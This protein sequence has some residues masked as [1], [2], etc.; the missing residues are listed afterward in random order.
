MANVRVVVYSSVLFN[1]GGDIR[2]WADRVEQQFTA[3]AKAIAPVNKRANKGGSPFPVGALK[4]SITGNVAR[5]GPHA[6]NTEI[7]VNVPYATYVLFGTSSPITSP[8]G[9][10]MAVPD[11]PQG[12]GHKWSVSG[13]RAQPFLM[14]AAFMTART[15]SSLRGFTPFRGF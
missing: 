8:F 3:N 5:V 15:H 14:E 9:H 11:N 12:H 2:R 7:S 1:R 6:L 13:Q 4:A 10:K